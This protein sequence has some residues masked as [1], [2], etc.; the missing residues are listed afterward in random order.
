MP[1][2]LPSLGRMEKA[3]WGT[4]AGKGLF[5][6][7]AIMISFQ[8]CLKQEKHC[9]AWLEWFGEPKKRSEKNLWGKII[10]FHDECW[11][12]ELVPLTQQAEEGRDPDTGSGH[13]ESGERNRFVAFQAP[14]SWAIFT[15]LHTWFKCV[16]FH[17][18]IRGIGAYMDSPS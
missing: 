16:Y 15:G 5:I 14:V 9:T 8:D 11:V 1:I 13:E 7:K 6:Q 10:S 3:A 18:H 4:S 12:W 2:T 17:F